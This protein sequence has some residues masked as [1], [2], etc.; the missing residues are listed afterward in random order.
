[1]LV[2]A[3]SPSLWEVEAGGLIVQD[4]TLLHGEYETCLRYMR[5]QLRRKEERGGK[6]RREGGWI[7]YHA[8]QF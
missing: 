2:H 5:S 7:C 6:E 3:Y 8:I 4:Q 1:M